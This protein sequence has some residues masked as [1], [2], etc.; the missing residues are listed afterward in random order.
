MVREAISA[1]R[2]AGAAGAILVRVYSSLRSS[3]VV[4]ACVKAKVTSGC[5]LTRNHRVAP[6]ISADPR[7]GIDADPLPGTICSTRTP[8]R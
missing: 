1:A 6:A 8:A 5:V 3:E 2:A 7:A 4:G